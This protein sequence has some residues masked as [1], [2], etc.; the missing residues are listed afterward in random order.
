MGLEN[1]RDSYVDLL[2]IK[3]SQQERRENRQVPQPRE[4]R[5]DV[6][7]LAKRTSFRVRRDVGAGGAGEGAGGVP[8]PAEDGGGPGASEGGFAFSYDEP[9]YEPC[10][11]ED[12]DEESWPVWEMAG[13]ADPWRGGEGGKVDLSSVTVGGAGRGSFG[14]GDERKNT[15]IAECERIFTVPEVYEEMQHQRAMRMS[16]MV[17][18]EDSRSGDSGGGPCEGILNC[19]APWKQHQS[20]HSHSGGKS[21]FVDTASAKNDEEEGDEELNPRGIMKRSSLAVQLYLGLPAS[22]RRSFTPSLFKVRRPGLEDAKSG[23]S[24]RASLVGDNYVRDGQVIAMGVNGGSSA[25]AKSNVR[26]DNANGARAERK[27]SFKVH[28]SELKRVLR[29]HKFTEDQAVEVWFQREDFEFFRNEMTLLVQEDGASRELA[30][31]WLDA[32]EWERRRSSTGDGSDDN[33]D[34][35][36]DGAYAPRHNR[37]DSNAST[38]SRSWWHDYDHSRRGLERYA[39]PGQ[40]RQILASYKVAVQKVLGEQQRQRFLHCLCIPRAHDPAKIA[41]VYHEYTA[42]SR[43]L[44][45]AAGASD[46]DAVRTNFD[47]DRRHTREYYMLKQVVASGYRVHKH[48]PNFMLPKCITP[49]GFLDEAESLYVDGAS[50]RAL[51]S[52]PEFS[53]RRSL[54]GSIGG[55]KEQSGEEAREEMSR[56]D[57]RELEGPVMPQLAPSLQVAHAANS[58][59]PPSGSARKADAGKGKSMAKK[60]LNYP[61][62]QA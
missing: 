25:H 36:G 41:E 4:R 15:S 50:H 16:S 51:H 13:V 27:K 11:V 22:M 14:G 3:R 35:G 7:P 56:L 58:P 37:D 38:R 57:S 28:F 5:F 54:L 20:I 12:E 42:W 26:S 18:R 31:V 45:L 40:A 43:D 46:A 8:G 19:F 60:A 6:Q 17:L 1:A 32:N 62:Q 29:V 10:E 49:R 53:R 39:S 59:P 30:E 52:P 61:F 55:E 47:D 23:G 9:C 2:E 21:A 48:M 33:N 24:S 44:A 34:E